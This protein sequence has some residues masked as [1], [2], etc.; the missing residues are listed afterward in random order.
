MS[1]QKI[2]KISILWDNPYFTLQWRNANYFQSFFLQW[3]IQVFILTQKIDR[4]Y[5][6]YQG[7]QNNSASDFN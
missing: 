6:F 3:E 5:V 1:I 2:I 7:H 4:L